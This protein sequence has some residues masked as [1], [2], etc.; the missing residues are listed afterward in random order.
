VLSHS[1]R[2]VRNTR[3]DEA[4]LAAVCA[5]VKAKMLEDTRQRRARGKPAAAAG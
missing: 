5:E 2:K 1:K 4:R 3:L